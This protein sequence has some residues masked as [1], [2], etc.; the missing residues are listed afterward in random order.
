M[1]IQNRRNMKI[2]I[3]VIE[4]VI[5]ITTGILAIIYSN[6]YNL[7]SVIV[8]LLGAFLIF[9]GCSKIITYYTN[10]VTEQRKS[11]VISI[12][13]LTIGII[14]C[15]KS[16]NL[17]SLINEIIIWFIAIFLIV[18]AVLLIFSALM[19]YRRYKKN[20]GRNILEYIVGILFLIAGILMFVFQGGSNFI[21][22]TI[23]IAGILFIIAGIAQIFFLFAKNR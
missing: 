5:L 16:G 17:V 10:P 2:F 13:E 12:F 3:K 18:I 23:V 9:D 22:F 11:L 21:A 7:Q 1:T 4:A 14:F 8:I 20:S 19:E 6:N 15:L